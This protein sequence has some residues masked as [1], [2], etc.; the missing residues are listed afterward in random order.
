MGDVTRGWGEPIRFGRKGASEYIPTWQRGIDQESEV[1]LSGYS[2]SIIYSCV[3]EIA[4]S[5]AD[6]PP[7]VLRPMD[8]GLE[9]VEDH[10]LQALLAMPNEEMDAY[11]FLLTLATHYQ[12]AGN[13]YVE[14]VRK[15]ADPERRGWPVKEL[16]L[17]RP[18]RVEIRPGKNRADDQ[19]VVKVAGSIVKVLPRRDVIHIKTANPNNDFYGLSPVAVATQE[20]ALDRMM[21]DWDYSFF[22]NAGVPMGILKTK[23]HYSP[24]ETAEIKGAFRRSFNGLKKWF[25]VLV[26]NSDEAEYQ[27]LGGMPNNMEMTATREFAE[28]RICA[29]FG[30]P[31]IIVGVLVGLTRATYSN[32]EQAQ[33]SFWS[34]TM[35]P[36]AKA[37]G[38]AFTR[39]LLPE[40]ATVQDRG[41]IVAFDLSGVKA[42]QE[43]ATERLKAA[44]E[45]VRTGGWTVN[46]ALDAMNLPQIEMGDFYVRSATQVIDVAVPTQSAQQIGLAPTVQ[47]AAYTISAPRAKADTRGARER[48]QARA[49]REL[50]RA[51]DEM[52]AR[53]VSRYTGGKSKAPGDDLVPDSEGEELLKVLR[54]LYASGVQVGWELASGLIGADPDFPAA[55]PR[56]M[57]LLDGA[58]ERIGGIVEETRLQVV[59]AL[60]TARA[61][62]L[63]I[64]QTVELLQ[65]L[66]AFS[67]SR[68]ETV[69]RTELAI[70]DNKGAIG[71]Y[72]ASGI[73]DEVDIIDGP[74]CGWATHTD[75]DKAHGT[76]RTLEEWSQHVIAHPRCV[77]SAAPVIRS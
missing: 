4:T 37:I 63:G 41:A 27:P 29:I 47:A 8:D 61:E 60:H 28:A 9:E 59:D 65:D 56:V 73:V 42:L 17:I 74:D 77:R 31:P 39:E 24:D 67:A 72:Q 46:Q 44:G 3:R 75:E 12:T 66:P 16:G 52:G 13:V 26:L 53:V 55:D 49:E 36:F 70:A 58:G 5:F 38:S 21:T 19:F 23:S 54:A 40:F 35:A 43:D 2:N 76:R 30:V 69:A 32:Y 71:R 51:F 48:L 68:A 10:P 50:A 6:L 15:S 34:E 45:L 62:G 25:E 18:D 1:D 22:R 33:F 14:K 57:E 64:Q 11:E 20:A 7:R